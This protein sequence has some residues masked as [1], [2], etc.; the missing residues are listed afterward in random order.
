MTLSTND[1]LLL[2]RLMPYKD[3]CWDESQQ[4]TILHELLQLTQKQFRLYSCLSMP[5][6]EKLNDWMR[7]YT[8]SGLIPSCGFAKFVPVG[9]QSSFRLWSDK[10]W[11][12]Q[13]AERVVFP[14]YM[15]PQKCNL[16]LFYENYFCCGF[17]IPE[18][19]TRTGLRI[20]IG[21]HFMNSSLGLLFGQSK[22]ECIVSKWF[23]WI[24]ERWII[25]NSEWSSEI[26]VLLLICLDLNSFKS[27][28]IKWNPYTSFDYQLEIFSYRFFSC[29][30]QVLVMIKIL[31][32]KDK[33]N[34]YFVHNQALI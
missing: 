28:L 8:M 7:A 5:H 18:R 15:S 34:A 13:N 3:I 26:H 9:S 22:V 24:Y 33:C 20:D 14:A 29:E 4:D 30:I 2:M 32:I 6:Q 17:A 23:R 11:F 31:L 10:W 27:R 1:N 19:S 25:S 21:A 16:L 12:Q